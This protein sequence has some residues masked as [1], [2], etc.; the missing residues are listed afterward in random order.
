MEMYA[1]KHEKTILEMYLTLSCLIKVSRL[2][3]LFWFENRIP[4]QEILAGTEKGDH[5]TWINA[6]NC[7]VRLL[8]RVLRNETLSID[9]HLEPLKSK[10]SGPKYSILAA[11]ADISN[12]W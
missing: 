8:Q 6:N 10:T 9:C 3:I 2:E 12:A 1:L 4:V 7:E 11:Q 5:V